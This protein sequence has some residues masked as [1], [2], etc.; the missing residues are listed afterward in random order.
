[1]K[2]KIQQQKAFLVAILCLIILVCHQRPTLGN[3]QQPTDYQLE[4]L[5]QPISATDTPGQIALLL[6]LSGPLAIAGQ[7][8]RD[9]VMTAYFSNQNLDQKIPIRIYDT[10][11]HA[12]DKLY[13]QAVDHGAEVIIGPLDKQ[14]V[15]QL[16]TIKPLPIPIVA[17]NYSHPADNIYQ[18]GISPEYESHLVANKGRQDGHQR[19]MI[20]YPEGA[21]SQHL[22]QQFAQAWQASGGLIVETF[23][24]KNNQNLDQSIRQV[25]GVTAS[26]HRART[27]RRE[28]ANSRIQSTPRRRQDIDMIFLIANPAQGRQIM[29]LLKFHYAGDIPVYAT[30][31]IFAGHNN[32]QQ[33]RD[34]NGIIFVDI[35]WIFDEQ[36][37]T[38]S[39]IGQQQ[40]KRLYA[41]GLDAYQLARQ[42]NHLNRYQYSGIPGQTGL[43]I[44]QDNQRI[45]RPLGW[46]Q[47]QRGQ[48]KLLTTRMS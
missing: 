44:L 46:A 16:T 27:L 5:W 11:D 32:P 3:T 30:S 1:M 47:F 10:H 19:A 39:L 36:N 42:V 22:S 13:Q 25:L 9:G 7:T 31:M 14:S 28:L 4:Y 29:P 43:L 37:I 12:I 18:F 6:P 41:L 34:L 24:Y 40:D 26:Q 8:V 21:W 15:S 20:I 23:Q 38:D 45:K 33:D 17:L 35:P 48:P 2:Y